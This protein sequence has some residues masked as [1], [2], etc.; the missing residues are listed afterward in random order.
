MSNTVTTHQPMA[1]PDRAK[2]APIPVLEVF[3]PTVQGEGM[4][5]GRKTM[6]VRTAGCD[7]HCSW[8]DSAFTWDGSAKD[9]I[10][11]LSATDIWQELQSIGGERFSHVTLSGGNPVLLPQLGT[12]ITLLRSQ[13]IATAV[14]TQGSRWQE[15]LYDIDEVTLSPKPPSSG[16]TTNWDVLDDIV[17]RLTNRK[18]AGAFKSTTNVSVT[19][20]T[21]E[22]NNESVRLYAGACSLKV[23]IFDDTDLAYART[24][25]E[26]YPH[27]PLFLQTGNPDVNTENT[28]QIAESLL[29]RY[30][31]LIDRVMDDSRLND[32]RVLPQLHTLVWG[33]KRGV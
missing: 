33:N 16:M 2:A 14:E 13:G 5:I 29:H 6:F 24:V 31:W 25:H 28:G 7:Y 4:V 12:L 22:S 10:R 9:Q 18:M 21:Q 30:E 23:V 32:V 26:R 3:G 15:W 11:R 20:C 27:V 1:T 17:A 8:C 19:T